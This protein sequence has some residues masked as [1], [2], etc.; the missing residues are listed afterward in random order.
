MINKLKE[1]HQETSQYQ[2]REI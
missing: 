2:E 1:E